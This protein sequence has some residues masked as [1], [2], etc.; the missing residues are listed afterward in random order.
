[1]ADNQEQDRPISPLSQSNV[2]FASKIFREIDQN[3]DTQITK[4]EAQNW[5]KNRFPNVNARS[6]FETVDEDRNEQVNI[7]EW[8]LFWHKVK[9]SGYSNDDIQFELESLE[10]KDSWVK[11]ELNS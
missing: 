6:F 2:D 11:F 10:N 1:M 8:I 9:E 3:N 7:E 4:K 5:W